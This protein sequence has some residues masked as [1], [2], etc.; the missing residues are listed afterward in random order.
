MGVRKGLLVGLALSIAL[1]VAWTFWPVDVPPDD[2][3]TVL[4][5]TLTEMPPPPVPK[6]EPVPAP[7]V[8][9]KSQ[10]RR[11]RPAPRTVAPSNETTIAARS[12]PALAADGRSTAKQTDERVVDAPGSNVT[13]AAVED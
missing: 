10:P 5:A 3:R 7:A 12:E 2:D 1:H 6:A 8:K 9:Q 4:E 13:S 11:T